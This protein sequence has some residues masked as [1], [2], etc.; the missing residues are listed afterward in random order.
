MR[1]ETL[2]RHMSEFTEKQKKRLAEATEMIG[3]FT[4]KSVEELIAAHETQRAKFHAAVDALSNAQ[5]RFS[6]GDGQ[7]CINEV[8]RHMSNSMNKVADLSHSLAEGTRPKIE[9]PI[10]MGVMDDDSDDFGTLRDAVDRSFAAMIDAAKN[11]SND[12]DIETTFPHPWFGERNCREWVAFNIMHMA[13]H[14]TQIK[15]IA[16]SP[17]FPGA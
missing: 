12:C 10:Q 1:R 14:L 9:V 17:E 3:V 8:C 11:L 7:W 13:V 15:R 2:G 16:S 6:P 4:A 5:A